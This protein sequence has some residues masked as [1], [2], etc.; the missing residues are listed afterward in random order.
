MYVLG[1]HDVVKSNGF[2]CVHRPAKFYCFGLA[3]S[4][5]SHT[6]RFC[7]EDSFFY[8]CWVFVALLYVH[9]VS[10]KGSRHYQL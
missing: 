8:I 2:C 7:S 3:Q 6:V 9:C 10:K 1:V 5:C 4:L